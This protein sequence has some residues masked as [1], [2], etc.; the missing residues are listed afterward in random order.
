MA[1]YIAFAG[2][3]PGMPELAAGL[4]GE[5]LVSGERLLASAEL[6]GWTDPVD[7]LLDPGGSGEPGPGAVPFSTDRAEARGTEARV[8]TFAAP[9][10]AEDELALLT[11]FE[12]PPQPAGERSWGWDAATAPATAEWTSWVERVLRFAS[13]RSLPLVAINGRRPPGAG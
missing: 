8:L 3:I 6:A 10:A 1:L 9:L 12:P 2:A 7:A 5:R 4:H 13:D 11:L